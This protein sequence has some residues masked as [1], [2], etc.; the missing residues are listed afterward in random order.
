MKMKNSKNALVA[1]LAVLATGAVSAQ[2][3]SNQGYY[4]EVGYT[5][6]NIKNDSNGFD[7][8]PKLARLIV[9]KEINKDLT[10]EGT[11]AFTA[12][13]DSAV[14]S[15]TKYTGK[16]SLFGAYL[17]PKFEIVQDVEVFA[18]VG[19]L[20]TKYEDEGS[21]FSKTKLSYGIGMQT[22]FTKDIYGQV[23]YMHYG[24]QD[25]VTARGFTVSVGTRF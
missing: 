13:K 2:S 4:G 1:L 9:G 11:Y 16:A 3:M 20:H 15:G 22:Q 8:T 23:D 18:R 12:S 21:N 5:P 10:L 25:S 7:I 6:L 24:K 14:V 19:A 17:K